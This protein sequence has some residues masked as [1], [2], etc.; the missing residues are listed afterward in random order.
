MVK[1]ESENEDLEA[2]K[3]WMCADILKSYTGLG[4]WLS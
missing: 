3:G 1:K 2:R 4:I